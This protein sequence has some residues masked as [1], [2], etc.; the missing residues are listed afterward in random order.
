[1]KSFAIDT[2]IASSIALVTLLII[3]S[4]NPS[5]FLSSNLINLYKTT[6]KAE[7]VVE[8]LFNYGYI[9]SIDKLCQEKRYEQV[10]ILL[11]NIYSH[12]SKSVCFIA[13]NK[14]NKELISIGER[15]KLILAITILLNDNYSLLIGFRG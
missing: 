2:I 15:N 7:K 6:K 12:Y 14:E 9:K 11:R 3:H 8:E 1:M 10:K 4:L 5:F 13:L